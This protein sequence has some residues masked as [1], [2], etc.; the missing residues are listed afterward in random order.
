MA[1]SSFPVPSPMETKGDVLN[2]WNYFRRSFENYEIATGLIDKDDKVRIATLQSV[3][4]RDCVNILDHLQMSDEDRKSCKSTLDALEAY[5]KPKVNTR[6]SMRDIYLAPPFKSLMS[7]LTLLSLVF[8][9]L[10]V[11]VIMAP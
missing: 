6:L 5:F 3:M 9:S 11:P 4:G 7:L 8:V 2:N 1:T 10:L